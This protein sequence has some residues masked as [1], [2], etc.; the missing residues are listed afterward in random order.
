MIFKGLSIK[1]IT[2][3]F[4]KG[5][6]P[7]LKQQV[8]KKNFLYVH[9]NL[10]LN[11]HVM[12]PLDV[13]GTCTDVKCECYFLCYIVI[14]E[15]GTMEH[16]GM[17]RWGLMSVN[18]CSLLKIGIFKLLKIGVNKFF[19]ASVTGSFVSLCSH[20]PLARSC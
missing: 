18:F 10:L 19:I 1:Q 20:V 16:D 9:R 2:Q 12:H 5:E 3:I 11:V 4:L 13:H 17:T 14:L 8:H 6:S 7:T 15:Q